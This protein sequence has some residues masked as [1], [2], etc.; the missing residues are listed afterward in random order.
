MRGWCGRLQWAPM[1]NKDTFT[2]SEWDLL[3]QAPFMTGLVVVAASPSGPIG[4][5]KESAATA[6]MVMTELAAC[7][8]ELMKA[9]AADLKAMMSATKIDSRDPA[10]VRAKSLEACRQAA[11]VVTAKASAAEAAEYKAW[12][13]KLAKQ[14]A[15]ASK[16]GGF[17]GFGGT[18]VSEAE[19]AALRDIAAALA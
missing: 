12:L 6:K 4:L 11:A 17:L 1:A 15:E 18:L 7:E 16:E 19:T 9:L 13:N 3:R 10:E 5:L 14:V 8:T 2:P